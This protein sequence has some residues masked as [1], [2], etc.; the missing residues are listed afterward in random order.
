MRLSNSRFVAIAVAAFTLP[1]LGIAAFVRVSNSA[2]PMPDAAAYQRLWARAVPYD[3]FT[4]GDTARHA[5]WLRNGTTAAVSMEPLAA[6]ARAI[7]GH[8]RLLVVAESWCGDAV[9]SVPYLARM[10]AMDGAIELRLLRKAEA[11]RLLRAHLFEGRRATPLV[12]VLDSGFVERASW[13]ER[14]RP[15]RAIMHDVE[16]RLGEDSAGVRAR[17]WYAADSGRTSVDEVLSLIEAQ[18]RR[19]VS[20]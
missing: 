5:Q 10:A 1:L 15:L 16:A 14:P 13:T 7:P 19:V 17:A 11:V 9:N 2:L 6:R 20:R 12:I 4:A 18:S 3:R 8:W